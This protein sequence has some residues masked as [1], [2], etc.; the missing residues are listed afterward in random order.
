MAVAILVTVEYSVLTW[1]TAQ[2]K[3]VVCCDEFLYCCLG[4]DVANNESEKRDQIKPNRKCPNEQILDFIHIDICLQLLC[5]VIPK[6]EHCLW[7]EK[8]LYIPVII[9]RKGMSVDK[10]YTPLFISITLH[11]FYGT[12]ELF[13]HC[14]LRRKIRSV[15]RV[16]LVGNDVETETLNAQEGLIKSHLIG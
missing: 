5:F 1:T 16:C 9:Y 10:P 3:I 15:F 6:G 14:Y 7:V 13:L 12:D 4:G 11:E 2:N 8:I